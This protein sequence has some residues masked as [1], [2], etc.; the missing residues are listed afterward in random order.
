FC[1]A[2]PGGA[3]Q[4]GLSYVAEYTTDL[5]NWTSEGVTIE[6][7]GGQL[8]AFAPNDVQGAIS[9]RWVITQQ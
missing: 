9:M 8:K 5:E 2:A 3:L 1:F 6:T 4:P 7:A